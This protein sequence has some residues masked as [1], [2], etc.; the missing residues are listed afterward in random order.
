VDKLAILR[1]S[2]QWLKN[3][4]PR[5]IGK[6]FF[7]LTL[8]DALCPWVFCLRD[9]ILDVREHLHPYTMVR[10]LLILHA[11]RTS[12]KLYEYST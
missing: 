7:N 5:L 4:P 2:L 6:G 8:K 1:R 12:D 9:F 11:K 10:Y 3:S